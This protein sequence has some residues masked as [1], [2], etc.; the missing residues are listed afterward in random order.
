MFDWQIVVA[1][2]MPV[3]TLF[4]GI[5]ADRRFERRPKVFFHPGH[6]SSFTLNA[7]GNPT[8]INT[9]SIVL[10]NVGRR[11]ATNVRMSHLYLPEFN[12][13][14]PVPYSVE[15]VPNTGPEIV[16]PIMVPDQEL[17]I[18]YLYFPPMTVSEV[19]SGV[20]FDEGIATSIPVLLQRLYPPWFTR[21]AGAFMV[22]GA[23]TLIYG[24]FELMAFLFLALSAN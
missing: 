24:L 2:A 7:G 22:L 14:P 23:I 15:Q 3:I 17:T 6:I 16:I 18:S 1:V 13:W 20:R 21:I 8:T 4:L 11:P 12:I 9:H 19:N 5:W 10:R